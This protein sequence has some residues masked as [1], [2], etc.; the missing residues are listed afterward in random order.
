M[1]SMA[2]QPAKLPA[3]DPAT[4]ALLA[5]PACYGDLR[6]EESHLDGSSLL[7]IACR[8]AYAIVNGIP[9]LIPTA[10]QH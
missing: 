7:C 10:D 6:L 2:N 4:L 1:A 9:V 8:R 5:C 3:F